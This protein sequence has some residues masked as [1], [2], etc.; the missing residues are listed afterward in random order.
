MLYFQ[1]DG[2]EN[3]RGAAFGFLPPGFHVTVAKAGP[4]EKKRV[5][6]LG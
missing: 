4:R 1:V 5:E 2:I 6:E 3:K